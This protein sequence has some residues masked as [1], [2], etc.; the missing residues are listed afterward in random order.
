MNWKTAVKGLFWVGA[1]V[2]ILIFAGRLWDLIFP[3]PPVV[4]PGTNNPVVHLTPSPT[5]DPQVHQQ[6]P[7]AVTDI[8]IP[9]PNNNQPGTTNTQ[10]VVIDTDG[11]TLCVT[12]SKMD[13]GFKLNP[14][15]I[16][17]YSEGVNLGVGL[18]IFRIWRFDTDLLL[19]YDLGDSNIKLGAGEC[20]KITNNL[21][22]GA[23]CLWN[24]D[25]KP[26]VVAYLSLNF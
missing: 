16:V 19:T 17:G 11:N 20:F 7:N 14:K 8:V 10:H 6:V 9:K 18:N 12:T 13:W 1:I 23:G 21:S 22:A 5:I 26:G 25:F 24:K 15:A 4:N 3:K 2:L